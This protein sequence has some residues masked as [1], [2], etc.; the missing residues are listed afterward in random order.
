MK[1]MCPSSTR[2]ESLR[3][4]LDNIKAQIQVFVEQLTEDQY[5]SLATG[6]PNNSTKI[7]LAK[8]LID[9]LTS[10]STMCKKHHPDASEGQVRALLGNSLAQM[11]AGALGL[12]AAAGSA[13]VESLY[14][15][16]SKEVTEMVQSD[17]S[18]VSGHVTSPWRLDMII[19]RTNKVLQTFVAK[20]KK[21]DSSQKRQKQLK[22]DPKL[23]ESTMTW[24]DEKLRRQLKVQKVESTSALD[25]DQ[26]MDNVERMVNS[27]NS[28][29]GCLSRPNSP[30]KSALLEELKGG[31]H[32][33]KNR[34]VFKSALG[35]VKTFFTKWFAK[36]LIH[37]KVAEPKADLQTAPK[38]ESQRSLQTLA[39]NEESECLF[40][41]D[42]PTFSG[43]SFND[44]HR[45]VTEN[46]EYET[47]I[48]TRVVPA[49]ES[50][51][52]EADIRDKMNKFMDLTSW[53][54]NTQ[55]GSC[56]DRVM[57]ILK[58]SQS[59]RNAQ[60]LEA[61]PEEGSEEGSE[62]AE[63]KS[64]VQEDADEKAERL[65][66]G[67]RVQSTPL[68]TET[69]EPDRLKDNK[70]EVETLVD[71]KVKEVQH[72]NIR[73]YIETLVELL[74][75][76]L[77]HKA[78]FAVEDQAHILHTLSEATFA[79][80]EQYASIELDPE[81]LKGLRKHIYKDL[82]RDFGSAENILFLLATNDQSVVSC[83]ATV[84]QYRM[85]CPKKHGL[86]WKWVKYGIIGNFF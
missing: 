41:C 49:P 51:S 77:I 86:I 32:K 16:I 73:V 46:K 7:Q 37:C 15:L 20:M 58:H 84:I 57:I 64:E 60:T 25:G 79:Q 38:D 42:D 23:D 33:G 45:G 31:E 12:E 69:S 80:L 52:S 65:Q 17:D 63:V 26:E 6:S 62:E 56:G 8:L 53:W 28:S 72:K 59:T 14:H 85:M 22:V 83:I 44:I 71:E 48:E 68:R 43:L 50:G 4:C 24:M 19:Q 13:D 55:L 18:D 78:K 66:V 30:V 40:S 39:Q 74:V 61:F 54:M 3:C 29:E 76:R 82:C 67:S 27:E 2:M 34:R 5:E 1:T 21:T 35:K 11:F 81:R 36:A 70:L 47:A 75:S 10:V 9:I